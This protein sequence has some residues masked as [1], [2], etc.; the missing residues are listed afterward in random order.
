MIEPVVTNKDTFF[1]LVKS[2]VL[3][4]RPIYSHFF[5]IRLLFLQHGF[6]LAFSLRLQ[7]VLLRMPLVGKILSLFLWYFTCVI[8][9]SECSPLSQYGAGLYFPHPVG[10][11]IG[12]KCVIGNNVSIYQ[13]VTIGRKSYS[14]DG[15]PIIDDGAFVYAGAK[16]YGPI[17]IGKDSV[18]GANAVVTQSIP[19]RMVAVGIPAKIIKERPVVI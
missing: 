9:S 13:S 3:R 10:V 18:I 14:E 1:H 19:N 8:T 17:R 7:K 15:Y 6:Q 5:F 11:I 4:W 2:D 16:I 12:S